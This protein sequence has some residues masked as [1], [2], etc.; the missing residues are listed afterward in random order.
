MESNTLQIKF[1]Q[2]SQSR[3]WKPFLHKLTKILEADADALRC[4]EAAESLR[5][6][7]E[8]FEKTRQGFVDGSITRITEL[9]LEQASPLVAKALAALSQGRMWVV[10]PS[11]SMQFAFSI[12]YLPS[13]KQLCELVDLDGDSVY[14]VSPDLA[15]GVGLDLYACENR[16]GRCY[17]IDLW[18][19]IL[20]NKLG[21]LYDSGIAPSVDI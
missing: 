20:S 11:N 9:S 21:G 19:S 7:R 2:N 17:E 6:E 3:G 13:Q 12:S 18:P 10:A 8:V 16:V 14:V 4:L 15:S 1:R 5:F